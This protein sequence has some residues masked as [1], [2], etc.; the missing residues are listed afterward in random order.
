MR[1]AMK[2]VTK[3]MGEQ[4]EGE[5]RLART[6]SPGTDDQTARKLVN[7]ETQ[8]M[9][10]EGEQKFQIDESAEAGISCGLGSTGR[11]E[12]AYSCRVELKEAHQ[13]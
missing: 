7:L 2:T 6:K 1:G 5:M 10:K 8:C 4:I 12:A 11:L 13:R 9:D 3:D